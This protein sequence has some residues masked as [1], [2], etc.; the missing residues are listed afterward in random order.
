LNTPIPKGGYQ[1]VLQIVQYLGEDGPQKPLELVPR[2]RHFGYRVDNDDGQ[3][4]SPALSSGNY[5]HTELCEVLEFTEEDGD[6]LKLTEE[7][8]NNFGIN[9]SGTRVYE[10]LD[11]DLPSE[12]KKAEISSLILLKLCEY[13]IDTRS[14]DIPHAFNEFLKQLWAD[15][16]RDERT[17]RYQTPWNLDQV[18]T[19]VSTDWNKEKLRFGRQRGLELGVCQEGRTRGSH[20]LFPVLSEDIFQAVVFHMFQYY[21]SE[22]SEHTPNMTEFFQNIQ[23]WYPVARDVYENN[24]LY[25]GMLSRNTE[26]TQDSYPV[27]WTLLNERDDGEDEDF[28]VNWLEGEDNW[29]EDIPPRNLG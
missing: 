12:V 14:R 25:R 4:E 15:R 29:N 21:R 7:F 24:I 19:E 27:L 10:I 17:G 26:I 20:M 28:R 6:K 13:D 3:E 16:N 22:A 2:L 1:A 18:E 9:T 11:S 8:N 23:E 5:T